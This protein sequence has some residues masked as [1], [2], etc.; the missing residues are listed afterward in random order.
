MIFSS[1]RV[2]WGESGTF[3]GPSH[4]ALVNCYEHTIQVFSKTLVCR[5][6]TAKAYIAIRTYQI[7]T[8]L[9]YSVF[10]MKS[11]LLI[12]QDRTVP[13]KLI[14]RILAEIFHIPG[15]R[16]SARRQSTFSFAVYAIVV[17]AIPGL[18]W[19]ASLSFL[20]PQ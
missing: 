3:L 17:P 12:D 14:Y 13:F 11:P 20:S 4:L 10:G 6:L 16:L 5:R 9:S 18:A 1:G 15:L 2:S 8:R 7:K 19:A